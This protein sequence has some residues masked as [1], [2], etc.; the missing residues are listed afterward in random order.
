MRRLFDEPGIYTIRVAGVVSRSLTDRLGGLS[1]VESDES[2]ENSVP[3]TRLIG[4]LPDQAALAGVLNTLCDYQYAL[5]YVEYLG[6]G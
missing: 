1:I 5:L 2:A 3:V 4:F 6:Q